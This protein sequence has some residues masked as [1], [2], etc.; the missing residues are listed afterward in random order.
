MKIMVVVK[1]TVTTQAPTRVCVCLAPFTFLDAD[2][3]HCDC[4]QGYS[5]SGLSCTPI[6]QCADNT[7][8]CQDLCNY[9]GPGDFECLC[10]NPNAYIVGKSCVCNTGYQGD[11]IVCMLLTIVMIIQM[12][13][14]TLVN[15]LGQVYM[16]AS[17]LIQMLYLLTAPLVLAN[18]A[19]VEMDFIPQQ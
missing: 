9:T 5:G 8:G 3:F 7:H 16:S 19:T 14:M 1:I 13:V 18:L 15:I 6:N 17:V 2:R 11:G 10:Q 4:L 12:V